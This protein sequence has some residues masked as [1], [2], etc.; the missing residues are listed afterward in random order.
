MRPGESEGAFGA[1]G[2][3]EYDIATV[4]KAVDDMY[5]CVPDKSLCFVFALC[6]IN[7]H[8][9]NMGINRVLVLFIDMA[10]YR[11]NRTAKTT[12]REEWRV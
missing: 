6:K 9:E 1:G 7:W 11:M 8:S 3:I 4:S 12:E 5:R 10:M 2:D